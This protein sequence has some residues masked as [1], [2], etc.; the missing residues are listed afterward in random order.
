MRRGI[1][2]D[3]SNMWE[4]ESYKS[5]YHPVSYPKT[6]C[7]L[8]GGGQQSHQESRHQKAVST[9]KRSETSGSGLGP[10]QQ[11][12]V[13][14]VESG[15]SYVLNHIVEHLKLKFSSP[16]TRVYQ[17]ARSTR[18]KRGGR[19]KR[20]ALAEDAEE[21]G[22]GRG[23]GQLL[24]EDNDDDDNDE[25][26]ALKCCCFKCA[27]AVTASTGIAGER[28]GAPSLSLCLQQQPE[29]DLS[30]SHLA[31]VLIVDEV[32]MVSAEM[33]EHLERT[34]S[35]LRLPH[36][37][38]A[39]GGGGGG[40]GGE[41]GEEGGDGAAGDDEDGHWA[42][43][44]AH[45]FGGL[46]VVVSGD[47]FQLPPI[48]GRLPPGGGA[49]LPQDA[50]MNR[51]FAF[52]APAWRRAAFVPVI[53][54]RVFRQEDKEFVA[55]LDTLRRSSRPEETAGSVARLVQLCSRELASTSGIVPT[56]LFSRNKDV[57]D[58]N[59]RELARLAGEEVELAALES[60]EEE[61]LQA[62]Q[63]LRG[64][65]GGGGGRGGG[66]AGGGEGG[67]N[68]GRRGAQ[69]MLGKK[70]EALTE[71]WGGAGRGGGLG[72]RDGAMG[73]ERGKICLQ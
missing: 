73:E 13:D 32:S 8:P 59:E 11:R 16:C 15:R 36:R 68:F 50:F 42:A 52:Q 69:A 41:G 49:Q 46:Q 24:N 65:G 45:P 56:Q 19:R 38:G 7:V 43:A 5:Q 58:L 66:G 20:T 61:Q 26:G 64:R 30:A 70:V 22:A 4:Q 21:E 54:T 72:G 71:A 14:L 34:I 28:G 40:Q 39:G 62:C 63:D 18:K 9:A 60:V 55:L 12:V 1:L 27:V 51:G 67:G 53:L 35:R 31:S 10:E 23:S 37:G 48:P 17:A 57:N 25:R 44:A 2:T 3:A 29:S 47:F 6:S 33:L